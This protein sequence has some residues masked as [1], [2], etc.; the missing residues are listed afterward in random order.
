MTSK[1]SSTIGFQWSGIQGANRGLENLEMLLMFTHQWGWT[2]EPVLQRLL[3]VS[4][5]PAR[6]WV[7]RGVLVQVH[8]PYR[9]RAFLVAKAWQSRAARLLEEA[10]G[11]TLSPCN[12]V[13]LSLFEHNQSAQLLALDALDGGGCLKTEREYRARGGS[14]AAVPDFLIDR[15]DGLTWH[16]V[17]MTG[18]YQERLIHQLY[19]RSQALAARKFTYLIFH[20]AAD[21]I[22]RNII[23]ELSKELLP[24]TLRRRDGRII[25]RNEFWSPRSLAEATSVLDPS[26]KPMAFQIP[27]Y[28]GVPAVIDNL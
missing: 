17:E 9:G 27:R 11:A 26:G 12:R 18:R 5:R 4:R 1:G 15:Y 6:D 20:C 22:A 16:E 23:K 19:M 14:L 28:P 13:A 21:R 10:G 7:S 8:L 24:K 25:L 2:T 3:R